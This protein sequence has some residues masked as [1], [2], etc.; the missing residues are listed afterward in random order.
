M[1]TAYREMF[2]RFEFFI[3]MTDLL[4]V[5]VAV[6]ADLVGDADALH[7]DNL[8]ARKLVSVLNWTLSNLLVANRI[9]HCVINGT[10]AL[11]FC[12]EFVSFVGVLVALWNGKKGN[13]ALHSVRLI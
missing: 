1:V 9:V 11:S 4:L 5:E 8:R 2:A 12:V 7:V 3:C 6:G 13:K 10:V